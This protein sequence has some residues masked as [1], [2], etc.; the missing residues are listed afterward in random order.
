MDRK[1]HLAGID[2]SS[3]LE[4]RTSP[5]CLTDTKIVNWPENHLVGIEEK[6]VNS[7]DATSEETNGPSGP[8]GVLGLRQIP[9]TSRGT[10]IFVVHG[11]APIPEALW[12]STDLKWIKGAY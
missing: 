3:N 9:N 7:S 8:L 10:Q 12:F 1:N 4:K 2:E 5:K 11:T 6:C